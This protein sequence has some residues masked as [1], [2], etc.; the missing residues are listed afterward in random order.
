MTISLLKREIRISVN[1]VAGLHLAD[2]LLRYT[3]GPRS[4]VMNTDTP[5]L[6]Q[7]TLNLATDYY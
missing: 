4:P 1:T 2:P 5:A 6:L 3:G 7:V